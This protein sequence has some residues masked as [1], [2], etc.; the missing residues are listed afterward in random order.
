MSRL[1][2]N[3]SGV[4][5]VLKSDTLISTITLRTANRIRG[6]RQGF[7]RGHHRRHAVSRTDIQRRH[8]PDLLDQSTTA[9]ARTT[10]HKSS[11]ISSRSHGCRRR[12]ASSRS[13]AALGRRLYRWRSSASRSPA[14]NWAS[15]WPRSRAASSRASQRSRSSTPTSRHGNRSALRSMVSSPSPPSTG[16]TPTSATRRRHRS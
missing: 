6:G 8:D 16:S 9:P 4:T 7:R 14:S 10:R 2:S 13:V 15:S 5:Y 3:R 12:L 1:T 11:K